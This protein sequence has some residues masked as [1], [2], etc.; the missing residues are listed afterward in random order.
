MR[1]SFDLGQTRRVA[2]QSGP[3]VADSQRRR[4]G[5]MAR[6]VRFFVVLG[7]LAVLALPGGVANAD[8]C[9]QEELA[10]IQCPTS[11][12]RIYVCRN[13]P[14]I[15]TAHAHCLPPNL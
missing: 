9:P 8:P 14:G 2:L 3:F 15:I 10:R 6:I 7:S 4:S 12:E 5:E 1:V 13:H 11:T